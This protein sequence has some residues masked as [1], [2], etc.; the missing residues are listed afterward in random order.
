[1]CG[2]RVRPDDEVC[3]ECG[4]P[5]SDGMIESETSHEITAVEPLPIPAGQPA[6]VR[7]DET[8]PAIYLDPV[9][10]RRAPWL[11]I[12]L[13]AIALLGVG[14]YVV[15]SGDRSPERPTPAPVEPEPVAV[16]TPPEAPACASLHALEGHWTFTTEVTA[17][18][19]VQSS[20]LNGFYT[21]DVSLDG[22]TATAALTKTGHTG[23]TYT[24]VRVQRGSTTLEL[25]QELA[26]GTFSLESD[27]GVQR[28]MEFSFRADGDT[29]S[30]TYRQR[31]ARWND[32]GLSGFL[33]GARGDTAPE[34]LFVPE[35]PCSVRCSLACGSAIRDDLASESLRACVERC[36]A[37]P[38]AA[39]RCGDA[40]PLPAEY[41]LPLQGPDTLAK[42][43]KQIGG[44]AKKIGTAHPKPPTLGADRLPTGWQE[45]TMLRARKEGGV[46]LALHGAAGWWLSAPV[47]DL[48]T[49]TRVGKLRLYARR[50]SED[51]GHK[52]V[53][54]LARPGASDSGSEAYIACHLD[55]APTCIR[56]DRK[57]GSLVNALPERT[58]AIEDAA[59][60]AA[61]V[62]HW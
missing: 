28:V 16:P 27:L 20:G 52:Y 24:D 58:L 14:A 10:P 49:G 18:R 4:E 50:L 56:V 43:C 26:R 44:C 59:A 39:A 53:L 21:I 46:R 11:A 54:G 15:S 37:D 2:A 13:G 36:D 35:Q 22:C 38:S 5:L 33:V 23:R 7:P 32:A 12:G 41:N 6:P 60:E 9:P 55:D 40:Q 47:F 61:G 42:L 25:D 48:P 34:R 57:R 1:M 45:V 29:L 17:S 30:G 19:V 62:F 8:N 51:A 31:G 3:R